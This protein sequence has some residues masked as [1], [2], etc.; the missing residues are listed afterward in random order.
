[1]SAFAWPV[2]LK[3][4]LQGL[5]LT[6]DQFWKLTPGELRILLGQGGGDASLS[7]TGLEALLAAYPDEEQG[8]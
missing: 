6:P 7:R 1:M 8:E 5:R 3:A 2:L 4:G